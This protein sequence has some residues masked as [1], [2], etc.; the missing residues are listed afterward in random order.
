MGLVAVSALAEPPAV[1]HKQLALVHGQIIMLLTA[2]ALDSMFRRN[3]AFDA[4][5]LLGELVC[6]MIARL[7][8][9]GGAAVAARHKGTTL[10]LQV[11]WT[12]CCDGSS[13]RS[14][15]AQQYCSVRT[16]RCPWHLKSG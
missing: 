8:V 11:A 12:G 15:C 2:A 6:S 16:S 14:R 7:G 4:R 3:P 5:R 1:L 10:Q 9:R 13:I